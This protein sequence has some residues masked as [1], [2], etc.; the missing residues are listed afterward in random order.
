MTYML[1]RNRVADFDRW[2]A[3]FASHEAA[4][5]EAGLQLAGLWRGAEDPND[6]FFL[7]EV[8]STDRARQFIAD[9]EAAKA[10][11]ASGVIEGE[12]HFLDDAGGYR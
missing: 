9:P 12:Y 10:G 6:V 8:A 5:R 3:V 1:C 11:Q 7:F 2:R 4:H